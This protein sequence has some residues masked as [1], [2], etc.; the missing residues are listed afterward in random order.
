LH[1]KSRGK[2]L[3]ALV[4]AGRREAAGRFVQ[5]NKFLDQH[6][7]GASR[8]PASVEEGSFRSKIHLMREA[9]LRYVRHGVPCA[10]DSDEEQT[11]S[12]TAPTG[13]YSVWRRA[14][15]ITSCRSRILQDRT[16]Q[17]LRSDNDVE[18]LPGGQ[19]G[20]RVSSISDRSTVQTVQDTERLPQ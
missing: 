18:A 13:L 2:L 8:H 7:P 16:P 20:H 5:E 19:L 11:K 15:K 3:P 14:L 6:H 1:I 12:G 17:L 10:V 4:K 9:L